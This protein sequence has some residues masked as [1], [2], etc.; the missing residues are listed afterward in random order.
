MAKFVSDTGIGAFPHLADDQGVVWK[1]FGVT[2]QEFFVIIDAAGTVV[3]QGPL[4]G[5]EL[6]SRV[7]TLAG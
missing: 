7:A 6:R 3:H 4:S 2:T 5:D 1:K